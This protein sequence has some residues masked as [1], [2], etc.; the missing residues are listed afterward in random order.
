MTSVATVSLTPRNLSPLVVQVLL[1][2][3]R[4]HPGRF[5]QIFV[6]TVV[7]FVLLLL[8]VQGRVTVTSL[9]VLDLPSDLGSLQA[10]AKVLVAVAVVDL[11]GAFAVVDGEAFAAR[12]KFH[13]TIDLR[14]AAGVRRW[15][16]VH[17]LVHLVP[18]PLKVLTGWG[19]P[20]QHRGCPT[21]RHCH[22]R[23][24]ERGLGT[25]P[26]DVASPGDHQ[27]RNLAKCCDGQICRILR[28]DFPPCTSD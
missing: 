23:R 4:I 24:P 7:G 5:G 16:L 18:V 21:S 17:V 6:V 1:V 10:V 8:Q 12:A 11:V 14:Q 15:T 25:F 28:H 3:F 22:H 26:T 19:N 20:G 2:R 13:V 9:G 27:R